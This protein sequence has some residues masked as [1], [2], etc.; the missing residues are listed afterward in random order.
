MD[1]LPNNR[2]DWHYI[3]DRKIK[4][5]YKGEFNEF[6]DKEILSNH[7]C[8]EKFLKK[9]KDDNK[10]TVMTRYDIYMKKTEPVL[11][12][13]SSKNYFHE[14]DGNQK[15]DAITEKIEQILAL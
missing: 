6:F 9:R 1:N 7:D 11:R 8:G 3:L 12:F 15:I 4:D 13:Y 10:A 5:I 2:K 14:I